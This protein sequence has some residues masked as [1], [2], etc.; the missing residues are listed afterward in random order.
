MVGE[1]GA[2]IRLPRVTLNALSLLL[3]LLISGTGKDTN[4]FGAYSTLSHLLVTCT[5][6][7]IQQTHLCP[8]IL[9]NP[10]YTFS[11]LPCAGSNGCR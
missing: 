4:R 3:L 7:H 5:C 2:S 10:P 8:I 11:V 9:T 1:G 6:T